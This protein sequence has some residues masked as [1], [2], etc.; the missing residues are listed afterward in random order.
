MTRACGLDVLAPRRS[1]VVD[2]T[3][4]ARIE[5][6]SISGHRSAGAEYSVPRWS[7]MIRS[8]SRFTP[9]STSVVVSCPMGSTPGPPA[10]YT[11]GSGAG[12]FDTAGMIATARRI[13]RPLG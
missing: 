3:N 12:L 7:M 9:A 13:M 5:N 2:E 1:G 4:G 11:I 8:R 10:M 6:W